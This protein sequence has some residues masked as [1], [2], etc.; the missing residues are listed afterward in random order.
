MFSIWHTSVSVHLLWQM[1]LQEHINEIKYF[2]NGK[3]SQCL[4]EL[5]KDRIF[6]NESL[7]RH[8]IF[9]SVFYWKWPRPWFD[10]VAITIWPMS[11]HF[12]IKCLVPLQN[13]MLYSSYEISFR[14]WRFVVLVLDFNSAVIRIANDISIKA[15]VRRCCCDQ[16]GYR[17][18][19]K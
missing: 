8:S 5:Q 12:K 14:L 11:F 15:N 2:Y 13:Q 16:S 10:A 19:Y 9:P 6:Q 4:G 3:Y 18:R 7:M 17:T 1:N